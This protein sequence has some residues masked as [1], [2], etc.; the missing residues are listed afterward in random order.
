MG[1][2]RMEWVGIYLNHTEYQKQNTKMQTNGNMV[3]KVHG[4]IVH[5]NESTFMI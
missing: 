4:N 5:G 1:M 2:L 3:T